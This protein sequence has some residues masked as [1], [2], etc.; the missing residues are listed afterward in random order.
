V[1]DALALPDCILRSMAAH[2][3]QRTLDEHTGMV[4]AQQL[5][6]Y[7]EQAR[8]GSSAATELEKEVVR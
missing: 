6:Q 7:L 2:A 1:E 3:R 5:I 4:R 8:R